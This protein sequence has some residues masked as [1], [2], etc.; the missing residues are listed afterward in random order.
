MAKIT[1]MDMN[2]QQLIIRNT[3]NMK[4]PYV[5]ACYPEGD[6]DQDPTAFTFNIPPAAL[7]KALIELTKASSI[8]KE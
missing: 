5:F 6:L 2:R 4:N 3:L 1:P 8:Q 7:K